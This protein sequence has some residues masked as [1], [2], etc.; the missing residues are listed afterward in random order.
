M[1][2]ICR[3]S[4][5]FICSLL[6]FI[7]EFFLESEQGSKAAVVKK[8]RIKN[9]RS[10]EIRNEIFIEV[11]EPEEDVKNEYWGLNLVT[12]ML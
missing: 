9:T 4:Q 8:K 11:K 12:G 3:I 2:V 6:L 10:Y 5:S 1:L 7:L